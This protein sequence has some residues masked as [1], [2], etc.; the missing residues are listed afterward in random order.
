MI[1]KHDPSAPHGE[2]STSRSEAADVIRILYFVPEAWPT[3]RNDVAVLFGRALPPLGV[4][5]DIVT[6]RGDAEA[7]WDG[8]KAILYREPSSRALQYAAKG[9]HVLKTLVAA[10]PS[11][12]DA[13][14][15]RDMPL[16]AFLGLMFARWKGMAFFHWLSFPTSELQVARANELGP[17][18]GLRYWFPLV[19]GRLGTWLLYRVVLP[20]AD[21][22]F[23]QSDRMK[24]DLV[25]RGLPG[26]RMTAVPMGVDIGGA[27]PAKVRSS[28]DPRLSGKRIIVYLGTLDRERGIELLIEMLAIARRHERNLVLV[29][30]GDTDDA[31]HRTA[32]K[33]ISDRLGVAEAVVWTGWLPAMDAWRYVLAAEVALSP[34]PRGN[35]LDSASPTKTIEYLALGVPVVGND[36]PDQERVLRDSGAGVCVTLSPESFA[37]ALLALLADPGTR[38]RMAT[39]GRDF[40][41]RFRNYDLLARQVAQ[42]YAQLVRPGTDRSTAPPSE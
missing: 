39:R 18:S 24:T 1:Q 26:A 2:E 10:K 8:G 9:W 42:V 34:I 16:V 11:H 41:R 36:N 14:Q 3:F 13:I 30:A 6:A 5:S 12:Y 27:D 15:V 31:R 22:I 38:E 32:L 20:H 19:Q 7:K 23:V 40:V 29:L 35:L 37:A 25:L 33:A 17:R 4:T 28:D 21:H